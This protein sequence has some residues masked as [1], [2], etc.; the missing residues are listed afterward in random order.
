VINTEKVLFE[1]RYEATKAWPGC[2]K[3]KDGE[4]D[5]RAGEKS[6]EAGK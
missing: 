4:K 1:R 3:E 6:Q 2:K 5:R